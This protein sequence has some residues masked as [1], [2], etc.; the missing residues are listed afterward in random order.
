MRKNLVKRAVR[1]ESGEP[2]PSTFRKR[3]NFQDLQVMVPQQVSLPLR[4]T[5]ADE[6]F[7]PAFIN[8]VDMRTGRL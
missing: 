6:M 2:E 1:P 5:A 8:G 7:V 3:R 4:K